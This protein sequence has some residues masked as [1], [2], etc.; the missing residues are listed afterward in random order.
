MSI[1]APPA[2]RR[3]ATPGPLVGAVAGDVRRSAAIAALVGAG[4]G[5]LVGLG[6]AGIGLALGLPLLLTI[7][8]WP[9]LTAYL[10]VGLVFLLPFAVVPLRVGVQLTMLDGLLVLAYGRGLA[11]TAVRH[12]QVRLRPVGAMLTLLVLLMA[13]SHILSQ[14]YA[15]GLELTRKVVKLFASMF[16]FALAVNLWSGRDMLVRLTRTLVLAGSLEGAIG[17]ALYLAPRDLTVRLLSALAPLGYPTGSSVL[18]FLPGENDTYSDVLRATGTSVDPNVLGGVLMI[19]ASIAVFQLFA[20]YPVLPR[21]VLGVSTLVMIAAMLMSQSRASWVGLTVAFAFLALVRFRQM[22]W[23]GVVAAGAAAV[24]PTGRYLFNRVQSGF[25]G[26][27]KA[28][29]MRL[30]EYRNALEIVAAHPV[31]GIG[32]GGPPTI[33]LAP[34]VSSLYLTIAETSGIPALLVFLACMAFLLLRAQ[35][36]Q[37]ARGDPLVADLV[38]ALQGALIAALTAGLFDH[39]FASPVFFHTVALFW[40]LCALLWL[41]VHHSEC[42]TRPSGEKDARRDVRDPGVTHGAPDVT[43]A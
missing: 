24:S 12:E 27:D 23:L 13:I 20:R 41:A 26:R 9:S 33:D 32:F 4:V 18:R 34:G 15:G 19:A 39:Y 37:A 29:G 6:P 17:V 21:A 30:D 35:R 38:V 1:A 2:R 16:V 28:A 36:A 3:V 5:A 10:I 43:L 42:A 7:L 22:L 11:R 8:R 31:A 40:L 25:A 14:S